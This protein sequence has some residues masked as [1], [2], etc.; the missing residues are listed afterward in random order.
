ME[1][2]EFEKK[3]FEKRKQ[4]IKLLRRT[5][6]RHLIS[7]YSIEIR[8]NDEI[9]ILTSSEFGFDAIEL[10]K[11]A[12]YDFIFAKKK[13]NSDKIEAIFKKKEVN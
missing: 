1:A 3:R 4:L 5:D 12:R 7:E 6:Y 8:D 9:I 2:N 10:M 11:R 13:F